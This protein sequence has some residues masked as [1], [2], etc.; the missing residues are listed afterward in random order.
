MAHKFNISFLTRLILSFGILVIVFFIGY[1]NIYK[2]LKENEKISD[3]IHQNIEPSMQ[4]LKR[5]SFQAL[6]SNQ[7]II[8]DLTGHDASDIS[9]KLKLSKII[10]KEYPQLKY[11]LNRLSKKWDASK[12]QKLK[13]ILSLTD[14]YYSE[15]STILKGTNNMSEGTFSDIS[16]Y[17]A[18]MQE[19]NKLLKSSDNIKIEIDKLYEEQNNLLLSY[20]LKNET[21]FKNFG[22]SIFLSVTASLIIII[23]IALLIASTIIFPLKKINNIILKI[24]EGELPREKTKISNNEIGQMYN[25]LNNLIR[26]LKEKVQFAKEIE[27]GN[28]TGHFNIGSN[29][30]L[31]GS[32]LL[33]MRN[34]LA[35]ASKHEEVRRKENE[36]RSRAAQRLSEFNDLI[37][38]HNKTIEDFSLMSIMQLTEYTN[39][40]VGGI[41]LLNEEKPEDLHL[42]L[43]AFYAYDRQ[44]FSE[45]KIYPGE[46][47]VGQCFLEK[48]TIFITDIPANYIKI[49][50][51]LGKENPKSILLVPLIL[52]E[53]VYGVLELASVDIFSKNRIE[54][55][56]RISGLMAST[57]ATILINMQRSILLE[58][59][60]EEADKSKT[61][62]QALQNTINDLTIRNEKLNEE[63]RF[64]SE[65][66]KEQNSDNS[67][68]P[69]KT[70][71]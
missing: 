34:S 64:L 53:K 50:S 58:A 13:H 69:R 68:K 4:F 43:K 10:E 15:I 19:Y 71:E 62:K 6:E 56:E 57:I 26:G 59:N 44:K 22:N 24:S 33:A 38:E 8:N 49:S 51:G 14:N 2:I 11:E 48:D 66:I 42:E 61:E 16:G 32:S 17:S 54:F 28:F 41:Y 18:Q 36:E 1:I 30:D 29:K 65:K 55:I 35:E 12:Q 52:N 7:F 5:L 47:L 31:L 21:L 37:S 67:A 39:S 27:K 23:V 45:Q 70:I 60:K 46:N 9:N 63:I 25:S 20:N 40:Q 3:K